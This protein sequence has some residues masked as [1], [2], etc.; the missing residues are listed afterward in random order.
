VPFL[1]APELGLTTNPCQYHR[2]LNKRT[3]ELEQKPEFHKWLSRSKFRRILLL[4]SP[5]LRKEKDI[6]RTLLA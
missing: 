5:V 6:L 3:W 1:V 2:K 4:N